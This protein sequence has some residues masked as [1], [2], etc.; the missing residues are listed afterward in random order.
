MRFRN[1]VRRAFTLP[2]IICGPFAG[3]R[4]PQVSIAPGEDP[5][6]PWPGEPSAARAR[7]QAQGAEQGE[8]EAAAAAA[9]ERLED[10]E[11]DQADQEQ[12]PDNPAGR[13][14]WLRWRGEAGGELARSFVIQPA[15]SCASSC[16]ATPTLSSSATLSRQASP[17][18]FG[19]F[20]PSGSGG[21]GAGLASENLGSLS[22]LATPI[23]GRNLSAAQRQRVAAAAL[24]GGEAADANAKSNAAANANANDAGLVDQDD[25]DV[26]EDE[27]AASSS[28]SSA[29]SMIATGPR[30]AHRQPLQRQR[31]RHRRR[32]RLEA[33]TSGGPKQAGAQLVPSGPGAGPAFRLAGECSCARFRMA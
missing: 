33:P 4:L 14:P 19:G 22:C 16:T 25:G 17:V 9:V 5:D 2:A 18:S 7:H 29:A 24:D 31:A 13:P 28:L 27:A 32:S 12:D 26:D 23:R 21:G 30:G 1:P 10:E 20:E 15:V 8:R 3:L 11:R 6:E